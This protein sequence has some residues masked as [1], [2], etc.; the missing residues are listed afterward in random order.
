MRWRPI[1]NSNGQ[2]LSPLKEDIFFLKLQTILKVERKTDGWIGPIVLGENSN[3][4]EAHSKFK[5]PN[6]FTI[7][8]RHIFPQASNHSESG[9]KDERMDRSHCPW[10]A[11][12]HDPS[13]ARMILC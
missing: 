11:T 12:W 9:K 5:R 2:I 1:P 6:S 7:K 3:E 8:G 13:A 4:M 10:R